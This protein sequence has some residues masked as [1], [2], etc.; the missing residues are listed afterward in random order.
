MIVQSTNRLLAA[1]PADEYRRLLPELHTI[2]LRDGEGFPHCGG[3]RVYFP[4]RGFCSVRRVMP[5]GRVIELVSVGN[6]GIVGLAALGGPPDFDENSYVQVAD[7]SARFMLVESINRELARPGTLRRVIERFSRSLLEAII[8]SAACNGRHTVEHR[9]VRWL[10]TAEDRIGRA[11]FELTDQSLAHAV[12]LKKSRVALVVKWL[13]Q[14][15]IIETRG[16]MITIVDRDGLEHLACQ[17]YDRMKRQ[18]DAALPHRTAGLAQNRA[19]VVQLVPDVTCPRCQSAANLPHK[20]EHECIMGID[21]EMR[22]LVT[23]T[24]KLHTLRKILVDERLRAMRSYLEKT[25][26]LASS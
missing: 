19:N 2:H 9:C 1:L 4:E 15:N 12:G 8:Q 16:G 18:R 6:E 5:D 24:A 10:L 3:A 7:G 25:R 13:S 22:V 11:Q 21:T 14:L 26:A 20:T 23:R 17:C